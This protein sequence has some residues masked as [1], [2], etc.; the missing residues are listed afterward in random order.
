MVMSKT[1]QR[2][3]RR[4]GFTLV[5]LLVVIG[6]IALLIS[7]LLPALSKAQKQARTIQCMSNLRQLSIAFIQYTQEQKGRNPAYFSTCNPVT[8]DSSWPGL[9]AKY[10]PTLRVLNVGNVND[11]SKNVLFCP[12]AR[13]LP[14]YG[15]NLSGFGAQWGYQLAAWNGQFAPTAGYL[16]MRDSGATTP[17]QSWWASSYGMNYY[18]FTGKSGPSGVPHWNNLSD[19][20][21]SSLTPMFFD[22]IWIDTAPYDGYGGGTPDPTPSDLRGTKFTGTGQVT[23]AVIDRHKLAINIAYCDG[24]AATV[25]LD[26]IPKQKWHMYWKSYTWSPALPKK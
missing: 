5:E 10:L 20:R 6:I 16:Y 9:I 26:D 1:C 18:L 15:A 12:E 17:A 2:Q 21:P 7:I 11:V 13:T 23:R 4:G 3:V 8:M 19:V 22:C 14:P 25:R 24:S